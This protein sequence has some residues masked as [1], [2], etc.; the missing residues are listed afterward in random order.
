M[1]KQ[2]FSYC[3]GSAIALLAFA[4]PALA[5][6]LSFSQKLT[7][8]D[9]TSGDQFGRSV[10]LDGNYT[11]IDAWR[12][13]DN[14]TDSGSAYLFDRT[15]SN[16]LHKLT[17]PDGASGDNFGFSVA[18][19]GNYTLISANL[20]DDN[21]FESGSAYLFDTTSG[22]LLQKLAAPDGATYDQFGRSVAIDGNYALV[23]AYAD[24]DKGY[25]SGSAYLFDITSGNLLHKLTAPDG[26][27]NARFGLPVALDGD[28][29]LIG[30]FRDDAKGT[31]SGSAYLFDTT[32]GNLLHKLTAPDG[33]SNDWFGISV[34][35]DGD[36]ALIGSYLDDDNGTDS[37]S[38]YLFDTVSGNLLHK[39]TAPDGANKD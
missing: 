17:A 5:G 11:L 37:G 19:D 39:L 2:S 27:V 14:G 4:T 26:A 23:G 16:L 33:A 20:D 31:D 15:S 36:Y 8:P 28:Y 18:I 34:E 30:S 7:A 12:N 38:A 32:T 13:D 29:A 35:L 22:N 21:G 25:N 3:A 24:D 1:F 9:G 6:S 10:A